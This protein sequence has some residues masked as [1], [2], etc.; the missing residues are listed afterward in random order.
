M[1][2]FNNRTRF[3]WFSGGF[4]ERRI[5]GKNGEG[6]LRLFGV[7]G[8]PEGEPQFWEL[9]LVLKRPVFVFQGT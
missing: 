6:T 7:K 8:E 1:V 4:L 3:P 2:L 5:P 9:P